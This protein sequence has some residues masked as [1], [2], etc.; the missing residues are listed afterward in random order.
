MQVLKILIN[1]FLTVLSEMFN[2]MGSSDIENKN[3]KL[4]FKLK[5]FS[6]KL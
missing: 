6:N 1:L 4:I 5:L 3:I 2:M